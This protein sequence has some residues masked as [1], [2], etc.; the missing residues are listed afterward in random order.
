MPRPLL[1]AAHGQPSDPAPAEADLARL[2]AAVALALPGRHVATATLATPGRLEAMA[3]ALPGAAVFPFFMADGWFT[4]TLLPRR[5]AASAPGPAPAIL[6]PFGILPATVTLA[7]RILA[8]AAAGAGWDSRGTTAVLAAHGS[9][10]SRAPAAAAEAVRDAVA[11]ALPLAALRLGYI[12]EEPRLADALA[13]S[14]DRA[15]LLPLFVQRWGHVADDIPAAVRA[16]GF[17]GR[18]LDPIGTHP[19]VPAII[20][21]AVRAAD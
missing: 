1:V 2:G 10:K 5:L 9:G 8:A 20:A 3:A 19:D 21:A 12:E 15:I 6:P 13:C 11:A 17:A 16:A 7:V 4:R 14:G 18:V